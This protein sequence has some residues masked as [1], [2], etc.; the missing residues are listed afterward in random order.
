MTVDRTHVDGRRPLR[1]EN[2]DDLLSDVRTLASGDVETLGNWTFGQILQHLAIA[3]NGSIDGLELH[4]PFYV[5][6]MA[7]LFMKNKFLN[8]S[9]PA[10][11]DIT[12]ADR[13][14]LEP[15]ETTTTLEAVE[16]LEQ[17]VT[18]LK[19][20]STRVKHPVLGPLSVDDWTRF[21]LRH[22]ELHLSFVRAAA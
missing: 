1:F 8:E 2:W 18:R 10:G 17:A 16:A 19:N 4:V 13:P 11:F 5:K 6:I 20:E 22:A 15:A 12:E 9:L 14:V 21:H 7:R 3:Y